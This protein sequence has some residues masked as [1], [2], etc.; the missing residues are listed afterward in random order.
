M[1]GRLNRGAKR[2]IRRAR[3]HAWAPYDRK[4]RK[5]PPYD[6]GIKRTIQGKWILKPYAEDETTWFKTRRKERI[7]DR[8]RP[9]VPA[10]QE[11]ARLAEDARRRFSKPSRKQLFPTAPAP[12]VTPP[13]ASQP[14]ARQKPRF[15]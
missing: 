11:R 5:K 14:Q 2:A 10:A 9:P 13:P 3:F 7:D 8:H 12:R 1:P 6:S 15:R 4:G